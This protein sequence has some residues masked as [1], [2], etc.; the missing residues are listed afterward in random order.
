MPDIITVH[1]ASAHTSIGTAV[2]ALK[3]GS[4]TAELDYGTG[5]MILSGKGSL[6]AKNAA[7]LDRFKHD[8]KKL[9]IEEG[10][11]SIKG[12]GNNWSKLTTVVLPDSLKTIGTCAK[13]GP[14]NHS[15]DLCFLHCANI[16]AVKGGKNLT[17]VGG[18]SGM[19]GTDY[20]F[21]GS[22]W[23]NTG[24]AK[25]KLVLGKVLYCYTTSDKT[26]T[27]NYTQI[28]PCAFQGNTTIQTVKLSGIRYLGKAIFQNC[29]K[30]KN[31]E[32]SG[33]ITSLP[34]ATFDGCKKLKNVKIL[35]KS[36]SSA[37]KYTREITITFK[38]TK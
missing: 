18:T 33:N 34:Y 23:E 30:L 27:G 38:K 25:G 2:T 35:D 31:V 7:K 15:Y 28:L 19:D 14:C 11:T 17:C 36:G 37:Q 22:K 3:L 6:S 32:L 9:I 20:A 21:S 24:H 1:A 10:I 26:V 16:K 4:I 29:T 13:N 5:V 12:L 8:V